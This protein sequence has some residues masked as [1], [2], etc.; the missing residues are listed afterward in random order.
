MKSNQIALAA[1]IALALS[2]CS[3]LAPVGSQDA[4]PDA[5]ESSGA[6][7]KPE[8]GAG[9]IVSN[10]SDVNCM[11]ATSATGAAQNA[12]CGPQGSTRT[13]TTAPASPD[14]DTRPPTA[15]PQ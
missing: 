15:P 5:T 9:P 12:E 11:P 13:N 4:K 8:T 1:A 6:E 14:A 7:P 2:G 3:I 10:G